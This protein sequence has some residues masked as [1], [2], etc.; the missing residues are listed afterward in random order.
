[1]FLL[2]LLFYAIHGS[3]LITLNV[4]AKGAPAD[5][6]QVLKQSII[7]SV[8]RSVNATD[9]S[10]VVFKYTR[11]LKT[12]TGGV[13]FELTLPAEFSDAVSVEDYPSILQTEI[14]SY[15]VLSELVV[16]RHTWW[17]N[18]N[19]D[20][21][22]DTSQILYITFVL[23]AMVCAFIILLVF[24]HFRCSSW[25]NVTMSKKKREDRK[26]PVKLVNELRP[27]KPKGKIPFPNPQKQKRSL[28]KSPNPVGTHRPNL[29]DHSSVRGRSCDDHRRSVGRSVERDFVL[30]SNYSHSRLGS[31][32]GHDLS[33]DT[34]PRKSG[35][36]TPI[37][38]SFSGDSMSVTSKHLRGPRPHRDTSYRLI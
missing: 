37:P 9:L 6:I 2:F 32:P 26:R 11:D 33:R 8:G 4:E 36:R 7:E 29:H 5:A 16:V 19:D 3:G 14:N 18:S 24:L 12:E 23:V 20:S 17:H 30:H 35:K 10:V 13:E 34:L 28:R 15:P 25:E 22:V 1:M 31:S 27:K 21:A 38:A